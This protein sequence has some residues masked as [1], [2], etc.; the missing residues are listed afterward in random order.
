[1]SNSLTTSASLFGQAPGLAAS[2]EVPKLEKDGQRSPEAIREVAKQFES[3]F[4]H[5]VF[6]SMRATVPKEGLTES[7]FGGQVFTDM[8]DQQYAI[9]LKN[10]S[11]GLA[12]MIAIQLGGG[13]DPKKNGLRPMECSSAWCLKGL[14]KSE[15]ANRMVIPCRGRIEHSIWCAA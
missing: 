13:E 3:I 8:L 15:P 2:A 4:I 7:G 11:L 1:M 9:S 6:K 14:W 12:D 5:Q 10:E